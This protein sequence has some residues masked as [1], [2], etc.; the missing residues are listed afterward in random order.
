MLSVE[1][2]R[3][4]DRRR[5]IENVVETDNSNKLHPSVG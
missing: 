3:E 4:G 1:V 2:V 5:R